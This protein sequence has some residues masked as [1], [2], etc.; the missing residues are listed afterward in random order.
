MRDRERNA[1]RLLKA[2][3]TDRV[4]P[5][6]LVRLFSC[7]HGLGLAGRVEVAPDRYQGDS[8]ASANINDLSQITRQNFN[9]GSPQSKGHKFQ[10]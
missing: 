9:A 10:Y 8:Y 5:L 3:M 2:V 4:A 7:S 1:A 6:L